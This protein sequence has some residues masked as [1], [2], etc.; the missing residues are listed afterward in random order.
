MIILINRGQ[1]HNFFF[2]RQTIFFFAMKILILLCA[3][4]LV[5]GKKF[6][7]H[8]PDFSLPRAVEIKNR[9]YTG[10]LS[11]IDLKKYLR[12]SSG[13]WS[14]SFSI[15]REIV[16]GYFQSYCG[17]SIELS[18]VHDPDKLIKIVVKTSTSFDFNSSCEFKTSFD[19]ETT[20]LSNCSLYDDHYLL[21]AI[22][23]QV[24]QRNDFEAHLE[25]YLEWLNNLSNMKL[26]QF[27]T[28]MI[29]PKLNESEE[30][31]LKANPCW[32]YQ[33]QFYG[34]SKYNNTRMYF[35]NWIV[36][37]FFILAFICFELIQFEFKSRQDDID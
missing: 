36:I 7:C 2:Q 3:I 5:F 27:I 20:L 10:Q 11:Y 12:Y 29:M 15:P 33:C 26:R 23:F 13:N 19:G 14:E 34:Q 31:N 6:E 35:L 4:N 22:L 28:K 25:Y 37:L 30:I 1:K 16:F 18:K 32:F 21:V 8:I 24:N 9:L 17:F